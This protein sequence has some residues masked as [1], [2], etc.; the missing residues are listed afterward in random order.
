MRARRAWTPALTLALIPAHNEESSIG[1]TIDSLRRQSYVPDHIVVVCDNCT[2]RTDEIA[3]SHGAEV[4]TTRD[5]TTKK[6]GALNQALRTFLTELRPTDRVLVVDADTRLAPNFISSAV[7]AL[8]DPAV[9]AV[10]GI[11]YGEQGAGLLGVCQRNEFF[12]YAREIE[13]RDGRAFVLTG[14]GTLFRAAVMRH[15]A[16][17]RGVSLPGVPGQVYDTGALT[18]DNEVTL[19]TKTL[20]Y[21]CLSPRQCAVITEI[22]P[23]WS[24]LWKQRMRWQ[25]GAVENLV[26]YGV[27]RTTLRYWFQQIGLGVGTIAMVCYLLLMFLTLGLWH[28]WTF[29]PFWVGIGA[30]FWIERVVTARQGG[31]KAV[32]VAALLLPEMF[33]DLF[34]QAVYIRSLCDI[35]LRRK[36]EWHHLATPERI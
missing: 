16:A 27:T 15:I 11:F 14:T 29:R 1:E 19:A 23:T 4:F 32:G 34:L 5:N 35:V 20:G 36:A 10:G 6:A 17:E 24:M 12:R 26:Q 7:S 9:G 30:V 8:S 3:R 21:R 13:R 31:V 18:E 2:D 33:Y 28:Q 22:M 25:R